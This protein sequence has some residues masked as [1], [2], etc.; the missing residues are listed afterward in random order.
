MGAARQQVSI[1]EVDKANATSLAQ[2]ESSRMQDLQA[3]CEALHR[4]ISDVT[5]QHRVETNVVSHQALVCCFFFLFF[6]FNARQLLTLMLVCVCVFVCWGEFYRK[7]PPT[8]MR[9]SQGQ[10][11]CKLKLTPCGEGLTFLKSTHGFIIH[12]MCLCILHAPQIGLR[13][14]SN[15]LKRCSLLCR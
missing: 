8:P 6:P 1:M 7:K 9:T 10:L 14:W 4:R 12:L 5:E 13:N 2:T 11:I 15:R 3:E